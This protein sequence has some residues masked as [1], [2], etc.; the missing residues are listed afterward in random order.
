MELSRF[1]YH[2]TTHTHIHIHQTFT[3]TFQVLRRLKGKPFVS[4]LLVSFQDNT[5]VFI[6][7]RLESN[8]SLSSI[9]DR[10]GKLS[11]SSA[12]YLIVD[13][14]IGLRVLHNMDLLHGDIKPDN[15]LIDKNNRA[16][17]ADFGLTRNFKQ[18]VLQGV[19]GTPTYQAPESYDNKYRLDERVD[20][21][22]VGIVLYEML[23]A[24]HPFAVSRNDVE[25]AKNTMMLRYPD[26]DL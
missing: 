12:Q 24:R 22:N 9:L 13:V 3:I 19:I 10:K 18:H 5:N 4:Q 17:L 25:T 11:L 20:I 6:I 16:V 14:L 7:L 2:F 8:L 21:F 26:L 1:Y 15:I 23:S